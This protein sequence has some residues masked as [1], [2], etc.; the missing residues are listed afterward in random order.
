MSWPLVE[1]A[2][3]EGQKGGFVDGPFGSNLKATEYVESGVPIIQLKNIK[4]NAYVA[5]DIKFITPQKAGELSR[6]SYAPGDVVIAKLGAVGTACIIPEDAPA[7]VIVADVVRFR[8]DSKRVDHRFLCHYLNSSSGQCAVMKLSRGSTRV[9]TNLS[10]LKKVEIPLPPLSEQK[11]ISAIL[12]KADAIR[13]KSQQA[14]RLADDFL[15][16]VFLDMFGDPVT[17]PKG[18]E[19]DALEQLST[20]VTKGESPKWQG[21]EYGSEGVRFITSENVLWGSLDERMKFIPLEFHQKLKRS[22]VQEGDLLINLVGASVGR[23]CLA[24]LNGMPANINQAVS[25]T[26][27]DH[28][29]LLPEIALY[30]LLVPSMQRVLLGNVVDAARA[31]ISLAGIRDLQMLV[32]PIGVQLAFLKVLGKVKKYMA[33]NSSFSDLNLFESL[34][35]NAFSGQL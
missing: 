1:L 6:H 11:R 33:V 13:R 23:A 35:H 24:E 32:P 14:I 29:R 5:K 27:L 25:V 30:Q 10:D 28:S 8:G 7:G 15:R 18:W 26:T 21:F 31:N 20:R 22:Q 3:L 16:A 9:R 17:N 4:P 12:D 34:S 2:S 19:V